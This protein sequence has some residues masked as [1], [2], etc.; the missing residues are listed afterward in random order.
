[1]KVCPKGFLSL[2]PLSLSLSLPLYVSGSVG[3]R[4]VSN[5]E[6]LGR[7]GSD[8]WGSRPWSLG[9]LWVVSSRL[10]CC[11]LSPLVVP[12]LQLGCNS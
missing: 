11:L 7:G 6:V 8:L 3:Q 1:M 9:G 5:R 2:C 10:S 12:L 4:G